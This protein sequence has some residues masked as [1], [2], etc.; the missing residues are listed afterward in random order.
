MAGTILSAF[1]VLFLSRTLRREFLK[2]GVRDRYAR[3][4]VAKRRTFP[5]LPVV[6]RQTRDVYKVVQRRFA[7]DPGRLRPRLP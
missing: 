2:R 1:G 7:R 5:R 3:G 4:L 6:L